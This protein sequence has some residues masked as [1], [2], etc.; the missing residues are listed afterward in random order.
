MRDDEIIAMSKSFG[1]AV[2]M[3]RDAGMDCVEIHAGHGYLISQF[4]SPYT[5]HRRDRWGGSL[6][7]RMRF[8]KLCMNGSLAHEA[9][10]EYQCMHAEAFKLAAYGEGF[11]KFH[12]SLEAVTHV[13]LNHHACVAAC[14]FQAASLNASACMHW[15]SPAA[16]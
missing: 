2:R 11:V 12:A 9:A 10:G 3:A 7:N 16:S 8:M 14:R 1:E 6:D 15:Y 5:N 4:L 13:H